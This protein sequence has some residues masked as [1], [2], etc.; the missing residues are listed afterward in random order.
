M[1]VNSVKDPAASH[2]VS[3]SRVLEDTTSRLH[4]LLSTFRSNLLVSSRTRL[5]RKV[6][7]EM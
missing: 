4:L 3:Y 7:K 2:W 5:L 1:Q 6:E